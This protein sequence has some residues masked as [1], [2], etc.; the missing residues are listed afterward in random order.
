VTAAAAAASTPVLTVRDLRVVLHAE[1]GTVV[2]VRGI[3]YEL[4][5]GET[6]AIVGESGSGKT[7]SVLSLLRLLP[8]G[9]RYDVRGF[10]ELAGVELV[11]ADAETLRRARG[12]KAAVV[13]Q[14]PLLAFNPVRRLGDQIADNARRHHGL[15]RAAARAR[16]IELLGYVGIPDPAARARQYPH[17]FSG[18]MLQR[19]LIAMALAAGPTVLIADEPMT[20]LDATVQAQIVQLL[21]RIRDDLGMALV[22]I[23]HDM[24]V[25]AALADRVAVMYAG[26]IV[27]LGTVEQVLRAP[28]HPYTRGLL[29]SVSRLDR[30]PDGATLNA[31]PGA[32]PSMTD[33]PPGCAFAPRC[34]L[35][36]EPCRAAPP[37]LTADED[38]RS[39]ACFAVHPG[40]VAINGAGGRG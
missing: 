19:A 36:H 33:V 25:V 26:A 32:P 1:T 12:H 21:A 10:A 14:D 4:G 40:S 7:I 22:L 38:G 28:Q 3:S 31:L 6:L 11:G 17:E 2:P 35:V 23:T 9:L 37:A 16:A 30:P 27:E 15:G 13:F 18:G 8:E 34:P 20:A 39:T 5:A 24:S 29:G